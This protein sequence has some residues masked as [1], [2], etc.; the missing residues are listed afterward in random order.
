MMRQA[1][2][3]YIRAPGFQT[4]IVRNLEADLNLVA[5]HVNTLAIYIFIWGL[6]D[7]V[8][9]ALLYRGR[10]GIEKRLDFWTL[11]RTVPAPSPKRRV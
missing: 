2:T 5:L 3:W 11:K 1:E 10:K 7:R 4:I 6:D 9:N 8:V